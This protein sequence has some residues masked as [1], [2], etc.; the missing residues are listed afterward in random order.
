MDAPVIRQAIAGLLLFSVVGRM[1]DI[2]KGR[3]FGRIRHANWVSLSDYP[4]FLTFCLEQIKRM[5]RESK[6]TSIR[7][8]PTALLKFLFLNKLKNYLY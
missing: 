5:R 1:P 8:I 4:Y 2:E 6:K 3:V 7:F